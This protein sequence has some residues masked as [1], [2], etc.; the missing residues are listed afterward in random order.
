MIRNRGEDVRPSLRTS[1]F[2]DTDVNVER[3][4]DVLNDLQRN[5]LIL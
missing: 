3:L 1:G 4:C 5:C 2:D